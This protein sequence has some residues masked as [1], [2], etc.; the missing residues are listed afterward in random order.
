MLVY[1]H[2]GVGMPV[3]LSP[4]PGNR[5]DAGVVMEWN[6]KVARTVSDI[7]GFSVIS[8]PTLRRLYLLLL[9]TSLRNL[10]AMGG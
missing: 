3:L 2:L 5:V 4:S 1:R 6:R 10:H 7:S 8:L 9:W